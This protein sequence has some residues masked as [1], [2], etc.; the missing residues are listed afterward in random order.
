MEDASVFDRTHAFVFDLLNTVTS[1]ASGSITL[2]A[3]T[4]RRL[5]GTCSSA[6]TEV[7]PDR[8]TAD[9]PLYLIVE[10]ILGFDET[11]PD[12]SVHG[13]TGYDFLVMVNGLFVDGR[14]ERAVNASMRRSRACGSVSRDRVPRKQLIL[15]VSMASELN[16]L[17]HHLNRFSERNR[18][19]RDFTLNSLGQ[20]IREIIA[21]FPV[22]RTYVN[23]RDEVSDHDRARSSVR[24]A[25][26]GAAIRIVRRR[27]PV[28][29][30]SA[31][32]ARRLHPDTDRA[33]HL[34]LVG[35]FQQVTSPVTAKGIEDTALYI[36][37]RLVSLNEVG[38]EPDHFGVAP[39][40]LHA[41]L[42]TRSH[43]SPHGSPRRRPTTPSAART[44]VHAC[45]SCRNCRGW[46]QATSQWARLNRRARTIL[47]DE[48]YPSRNEEF[49]LYQ[50]LVGSWPLQPMTPAEERD[51]CERIVTYMHKA[52]REAKLYTSWIN[53]SEAHEAAMAHFIESVLSPENAA[54]R[55]SFL[56]FERR[57]RTMDLHCPVAARD[58]DW[59]TRDSRFLPG[60][61]A[62]DVHAGRSRQPA[63][64]RLSAPPL[65]APGSGL[66][67]RAL[68]PGGRG[69]RGDA[70]AARRSPEAVCH[71][72]DA[73]IQTEPPELFET[74]AYEPADADGG[75]R[76]HVFGFARTLGDEQ[77][78][79][80]VPRLV[81]SLVP[82]A[83]I[84]PIGER[85]W[86]TRGSSRRARPHAAATTRVHQ[87][88]P[89]VQ[90]EAAA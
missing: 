87:S 45:T 40:D 32:E 17:A 49:L 36:Y 44:F 31:A 6:G 72:D 53:P 63:A 5:S 16:V 8:F 34:T 9:Q 75:R 82:D 52:M 19:Y 58:Q 28:R 21:C 29:A 78:L 67:S 81:A 73:A 71:D 51:Y 79:V 89:A 80:V 47:N 27:L 41:W 23:E 43:R 65:A 33:A 26:R 84:P 62:V 14:N 90:D 37:N 42:R 50:T 59:R 76:D 15:R 69:R 54:F 2:T 57:V 88:L 70:I 10:K 64:G 12:W 83:D 66:M 46:K 60:D 35:K 13:T 61:G 85:V 4:T 3:S 38:G 20:A 68:G 1:T 86:A 77:V 18:H 74:G 55:D 30:R 25:K 22:Y 56:D 11:L 24:F 7:R 39:G 48:S